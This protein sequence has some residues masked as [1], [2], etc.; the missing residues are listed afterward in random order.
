MV[1]SYIAQLYWRELNNKL[2]CD[3]LCIDV[4][5]NFS[6][7]Y[8]QLNYSVVEVNEDKII[9]YDIQPFHLFHP[10]DIKNGD[11][12]YV[13]QHPR[14]GSLAFSSSESIVESV[15]VCVCACA[16]VCV[17]MCVCACVRACVCVCMCVCVCVCAC[18][19][20]RACVCVCVCV[21]V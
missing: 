14:G 7:V 9:D 1:Y 18:V 21:R 15:H 10:A 11:Q 20:V 17:F 5:I 16:C 19:C 3:Y 2:A 8:T 12:V 4:N 6:C 13:I